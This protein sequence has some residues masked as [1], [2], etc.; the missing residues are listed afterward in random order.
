MWEIFLLAACELE[1]NFDHLVW[2][3]SLPQIVLM[4]DYDFSRCSAMANPI[5]TTLTGSF[6]TLYEPPEFINVASIREFLVLSTF[7][8][9]LEI[10]LFPCFFKIVHPWPKLVLKVCLQLGTFQTCRCQLICTHLAG[11]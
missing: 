2:P 4:K 8:G 7:R 3:R 5:A 1:P 10:L 6:V 9:F 11:R